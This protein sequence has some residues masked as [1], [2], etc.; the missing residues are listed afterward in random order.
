M[1]TLTPL[2]NLSL[3]HSSTFIQCDREK[4]GKSLLRI[5][6]MVFVVFFFFLFFFFKTCEMESQISLE[7]VLDIE[8]IIVFFKVYLWN[9]FE[10]QFHPPFFLWVSLCPRTDRLRFLCFWGPYS[11]MKLLSK[12]RHFD[13]ILY[14]GITLALPDYGVLCF[15]LFS[16]PLYKSFDGY[17]MKH[18]LVFV[19]DEVNADFLL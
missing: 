8:K 4:R 12:K 5:W 16:W 18:L 7:K 15:V 1:L 13:K 11:W 19:Y 3:E 6:Y 10:L 14:V 2:E 17:W 9:Y